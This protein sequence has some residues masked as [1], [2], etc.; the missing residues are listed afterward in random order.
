MATSIQTLNAILNHQR[1]GFNTTPY[2]KWPARKAA[3][4]TLGHVIK[5]HE[6]AFIESINADFGQRAAEET[7]LAELVIIESG[8]R[9]ALKHTRSRMQTR[10]VSTSLAFWPAKSQ[11]TP[12]PLGVIGII[13]PWNYP[14]QLAIMPMID[15]LA[16]GN[17]VM[18]K[19]S[20][21]TP[22]T[23]ALLKQILEN[24]FDSQQVSVVTGG[25]DIAAAFSAL[26]FDHLVFTG[27]TQVG[28]L[29]ASAAAKNLTPCTLELGGKS[30]VI[31]DKSAYLPLAAKRIAT[32]KLLNA[33][34]TCVAP[35]YILMPKDKIDDFTQNLLKTAQTLYPH[36][37][38]NPD[39][40]S[41]ISDAQFKR[42][43]D[44]LADA[45]AK[46]ASI[47]VASDEPENALKAA[48][49]IP[50]TI[51]TG[52]T[53]D[54]DIMREEIFGPLLPILECKNTQDALDY[55]SA[56]DRPLAL[57]WF[58]NDKALQYSILTQSHSGGI[59]INECSLHV[60]QDGLPFGGIGPSGMGAY[61]GRHGFEQLSHMKGVFIQN[62]FAQTG[63]FA[64]PYTEKTRKLLQLF[65][66]FL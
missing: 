14:L 45:K 19:P 42:L 10:T 32:G 33:G 51:L 60:I 61:H 22:K 58:G 20:E 6:A 25:P 30:P 34:Q 16:A 26:P 46:G 35:D 48:R 27:S 40:S 38:D 28:R 59:C 9:H 52:L 8:I 11:I 4:T 24:A 21:M 2:P 1:D 55:V 31:I 65:R 3:L 53:A 50:L 41:I 5:E 29:V 37:S 57:Y 47:Y 66:R 62:R 49:K 17:R 23:S 13:S 36:L 44:L 54:M 12:Q 7:L 63:L 43:N 64:P 15:A 56:Q 39:Y 18:L